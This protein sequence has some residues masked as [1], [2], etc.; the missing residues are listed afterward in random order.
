MKFITLKIAGSF[1]QFNNAL[2]DDNVLIITSQSTEQ[3]NSDESFVAST[4]FTSEAIEG[5]KVRKGG[6]DAQ[7]AEIGNQVS[8]FIKECKKLLPRSAVLSVAVS[9]EPLI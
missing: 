2:K 7:D 4:H 3:A 1:D 6:F 8:K 9:S 5:D